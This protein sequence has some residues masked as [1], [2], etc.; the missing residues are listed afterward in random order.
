MKKK[1]KTKKKKEYRLFDST[2][3]KFQELGTS[4]VLT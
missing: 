1:E 4:F 2:Y 3:I